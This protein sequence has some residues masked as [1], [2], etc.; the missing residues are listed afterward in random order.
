ML[1]ELAAAAAAILIITVLI[2][3]IFIRLEQRKPKKPLKK[4]KIGKDNLYQGLCCI[5]TSAVYFFIWIYWDKGLMENQSAV[6]SAAFL[7]FGLRFILSYINKSFEYDLDG[8]KIKNIFG[9][10]RKCS[11]NRILKAYRTS[12]GMVF[13]TC[14]GHKIR[15]SV[16]FNGISEFFETAEKILK[17]EDYKKNRW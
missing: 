3:P 7:I 14:D 9:V 10:T 5:F 6:L 2:D 13:Y 1:T 12:G 4:M 11:Y 15:V 17:I 8:F 16:Q